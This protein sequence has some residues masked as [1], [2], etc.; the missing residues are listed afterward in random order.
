M[1]AKMKHKT[2]CIIN[3]DKVLT[4]FKAVVFIGYRLSK[5]SERV[6]HTPGIGRNIWIISL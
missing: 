5:S 3:H 2:N 1:H 6:S 4:F